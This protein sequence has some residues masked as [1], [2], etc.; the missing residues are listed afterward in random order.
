VLATNVTIH[1]NQ[2]F[3]PYTTLTILSL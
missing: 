1:S 3:F 2:H